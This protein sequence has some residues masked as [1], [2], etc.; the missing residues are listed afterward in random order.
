MAPIQVRNSMGI[1]RK[2][3]VA[4]IYLDAIDLRFDEEELS[5]KLGMILKS[6]TPS[7]K[8]TKK[9]KKKKCFVEYC[10]SENSACSRVAYKR[11][12]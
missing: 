10:C 9:S 5:V 6:N 11:M 12:A 3:K 8:K 7:Q 2:L 1:Y 4:S